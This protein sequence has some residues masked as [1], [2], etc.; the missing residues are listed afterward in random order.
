MN[1][2]TITH[3][4]TITCNRYANLYNFTS[5]YFPYKHNSYRENILGIER[6]TIEDYYKIIYKR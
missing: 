4:Y 6:I 3:I 1:I 2:C 5:I